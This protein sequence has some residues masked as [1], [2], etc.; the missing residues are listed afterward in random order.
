MDAAT[1]LDRQEHWIACHDCD[2]LLEPPELAHGQIAR[3]PRCGAV[4]RQARAR[5]FERS[6]AFALAGLV[7][8]VVANAFPF[9]S[10]GLEGRTQAMTITAGAVGL[11]QGGYPMLA[12]LVLASSVVVPLL[13]LG[14]QLAVAGRM[15]RERPLRGL[16]RA[17]R[18][19]LPMRPWAMLEVYLL[20]V[21]VAVV[22]LAQMASVELGVGFYAFLGLVLATS[23]VASLLDPH[24]VWRRD[25]ATS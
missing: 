7:C 24:E 11:W 25:G 21:L 5:A 3:C 6:L 19:L 2:L 4:V 14:T 12:A 18:W 1:T 9:L 13:V 16:G 23:A 8:F 15:H 10:F 20:G 22:K 17:L